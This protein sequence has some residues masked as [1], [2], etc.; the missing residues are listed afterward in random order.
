MHDFRADMRPLALLLGTPSAG[1]VCF[2]APKKFGRLD[3]GA[4]TAACVAL[5]L[6]A[7][8]LVPG[9]C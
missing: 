8:R 9:L 1:S 6:L 7:F 2:R 3:L 5:A 4:E